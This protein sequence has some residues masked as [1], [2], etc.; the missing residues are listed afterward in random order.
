MGNA[1][2]V[3]PKVLYPLQVQGQ[4]SPRLT[5]CSEMFILRG[6]MTCDLS[7]AADLVGCVSSAARSHPLVEQALPEPSLFRL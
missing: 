5:P 7:Q 6:Q 2:S 1:W 4:P 3:L